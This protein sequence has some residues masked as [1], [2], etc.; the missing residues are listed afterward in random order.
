M[1]EKEIAKEGKRLLC[2][3]LAGLCLL[4]LPGCA[5][6][7]PVETQAPSTQPTQA[8][9]ELPVTGNGDPESL[10]CKGSYTGSSLE[11][12]REETVAQAG[13]CA[14]TLGQLRIRYALAVSEYRQSGKAPAPN[15]DQ[16]LESQPCPLEEGLSW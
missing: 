1:K 9:P 7:E 2:L 15:F 11:P 4:G 16:S 10:L 5:R 6:K 8:Q 14:L 13:N 12:S 3:L